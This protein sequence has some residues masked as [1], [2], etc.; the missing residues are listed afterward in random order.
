MEEQRLVRHNIRLYS[1]A[2][3]ARVMGLNIFKTI[4]SDWFLIESHRCHQNITSQWT[5]FTINDYVVIISIHSSIDELLVA[6]S[7][8]KQGLERECIGPRDERV[9]GY[10]YIYISAGRIVEG[11]REEKKKFRLITK[12][13]EI[14]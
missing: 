12:L 6:W 2:A 8:Y 3:N 9:A 5:R 10:I 11:K 4:I 14:Y 7:H 13:N 1:R